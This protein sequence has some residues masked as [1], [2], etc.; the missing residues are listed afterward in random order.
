M[1][2]KSLLSPVTSTCTNITTDRKIK[3]RASRVDNA[4]M[5]PTGR[6]SL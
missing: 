1:L 4:N 2:K 3:K 5:D 6:L